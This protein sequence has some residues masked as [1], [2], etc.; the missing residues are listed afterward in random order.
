MGSTS[1]VQ[2]GL[3]GLDRPLESL[4]GRRV[5]VTGGSRGIGRACAEA[6]LE[7]GARVVIAARDA[8]RLQG[9]EG[10]LRGQYGDAVSSRVADVADV[11]AVDELVAA[12]AEAL[13]GLDGLVHA[14]GV[15]GPVGPAEEQSPESWWEAVRV[16]LLGTFLV[17]GAAAR[18]M[19]A[20]GRMV[21]LSGGGATGPFP[22]FS[23]Y[24]AGKAAVVRLVE[25]LAH[26]W[27]GRLEINA[28][29]P[30]FV[31]TEIHEATLAAGSAAGE[32]YLERTRR[33]LESGG[34]PAELAGRAAVFLLSD[35]AAGI[36]GRLLAAPWD[37]WWEWPERRDEIAAGDLYT[38]RRIVD[39]DRS[40]S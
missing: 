40:G 9:T 35:R 7:A 26:E 30:G 15:I 1:T 12:A 37:E 31:A 33:E 6:A 23:A 36:T 14:A 39:R 27:A 4:A 25:T 24:G 28:L 19:P 13:G 16:N 22:N 21:A 29:A 11:A 32:E 10:E 17:A 2:R 34:V 38:L 18:V 5:L 20:G 8:G 3:A